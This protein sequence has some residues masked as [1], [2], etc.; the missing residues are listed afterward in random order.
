MFLTLA[1]SGMAFAEEPAETDVVD[2]HSVWSYRFEGGE[3]QLLEKV[4]GTQD[5][6]ESGQKESESPKL[7]DTIDTTMYDSPRHKNE[8]ADI[9]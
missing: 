3:Q 4:S 6:Q 5:S 2:R 8:V 9:D 1:G 7:V